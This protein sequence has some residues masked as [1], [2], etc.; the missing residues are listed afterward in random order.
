[1]ATSEVLLLQHED[2]LV[3]CATAGCILPLAYDAAGVGIA[4]VAAQCLSI[5]QDWWRS[6]NSLG[7]P[8]R[9]THV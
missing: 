1:M 3:G 2:R 8:F 9:V 6:G 7:L 5:D 4:D